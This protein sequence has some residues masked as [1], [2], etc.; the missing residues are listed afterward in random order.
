MIHKDW[1]FFLVD[2]CAA[3]GRK[4]AYVAGYSRHTWIFAFVSLSISARGSP[5]RDAEVDSSI[6]YSIQAF[7]FKIGRS[8]I[9]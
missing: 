9:Y 7:L 4:R 5:K 8:L 1:R 3:K 6:T 2:M